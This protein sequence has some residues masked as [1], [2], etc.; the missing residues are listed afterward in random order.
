MRG[1]EGIAP[2]AMLLGFS[3]LTNRNS[4]WSLL[5]EQT[6][7][8]SARRLF[9]LLTPKVS[10]FLGFMAARCS[11]DGLVLQNGI[12]NSYFSHFHFSMSMHIRNFLPF[13]YCQKPVTMTTTRRERKMWKFC[14]ANR[15][16]HPLSRGYRFVHLGLDVEKKNH[17]L[18][19]KLE[20]QKKFQLGKFL[21]I[22]H[23]FFQF[24]DFI[25]NFKNSEFQPLQ[26]VS[27]TN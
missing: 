16:F 20:T 13:Y 4:L 27:Y 18:I 21:V 10:C 6:H 8:Q 7:F 24:L 11:N 12:K 15:N 25:R 19:V 1:C 26:N 5:N 14:A 17:T 23:H 9:A 22:L 3:N 2:E